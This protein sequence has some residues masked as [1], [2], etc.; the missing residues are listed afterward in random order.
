MRRPKAFLAATALL[1]ACFALPACGSSTVSTAGFVTSGDCAKEETVV[2][3]ALDR[4]R[5]RVDVDGDGRLDRV[6]VATDHD[7]GKRCRAF[8][9][10][11]V[12][13]GSTYSTHLYRGAVPP[14]R[15]RARIVG[16]PVLGDEPGA[17]IVVDTRAAVDSVLAQMFTLTAGG[18]R[19]VQVPVFEDGTFIIEGGGITYPH[20]A[21]CTADGR[22]VLSEAEL[23]KDG[24]HYRVTRASYAFQGEPTRLG[25]EVTT[26]D[27]VRADRLGERFPEFT[28]PHWADCMGTV[29][30]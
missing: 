16:L 1:A 18:L 28:R 4:S 27:T 8:V 10:V 26:S 11:R 29:R 19:R 20:G 17:Q 2:R 14:E 15:L 12:R 6:A 3:R 24:N 22:L 25:D 30:L 5:L 21:A 13:G 7:A 23:T 9:G